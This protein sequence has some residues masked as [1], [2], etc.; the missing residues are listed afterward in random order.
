MKI[1]YW[2][3]ILYNVGKKNII[4]KAISKFGLCYYSSIINFVFV[5][6]YCGKCLY[7]YYWDI[8]SKISAWAS[9][10]ASVSLSCFFSIIHVYAQRIMENGI[11]MD[12]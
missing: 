5:F 10:D 12:P 4:V 11:I 6:I 7:I 2:W 3:D 9:K 8:S 1:S